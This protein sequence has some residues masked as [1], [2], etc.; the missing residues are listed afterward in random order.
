MTRIIHLTDSYSQKKVPFRPADD[1]R[2]TVYCCGPTVYAA[3]HIG[4]ARAG[5]VADQMVRLLR[6]VYGDGSVVYA[7]NLTDIDDKIIKASAEEGVEIDVITARATRLYLDDLEALGC[8]L[9]DMMP[10]ATEHIGAMQAMITSL[11]EQEFAYSAEGHVLFSTQAFGAYGALSRL[12]RDAMIAGARVEVAPYKR[13]PADFVLWKPAKEGEPGWDAPASWNIEGQGRPG[14]HI[15]CSAMIEENLGTPIDLH[16]GGLDLRFPHHEN[17]IAQSCC[18]KDLGGV[19]LARHWM[20][21][22]MLN[23]GADKM[24][25]SL[26]NIVTPGELLR[27]WH[28][29][30]LR[31]ALLSAHYRG[32]LEW[33][34]ELLQASKAQLDK[35]YRAAGDAEPGDLP[36]GVLDALADDLNTAGA[37]AA[38]HALREK[39]QAGDK[40]AKAQ[41]RAGGQLLGIMQQTEEAWFRGEASDDDARIDALLAERAEARKTRDF[42]RAD[43]IRDELSAEGIVIE[44]GPNGATWRRE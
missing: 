2:V 36:N 35:F 29:E 5:V 15:E 24:S 4:N 44:D 12:D 22:G 9:P 43:A 33:T 17:E 37:I 7:R 42:A 38:L 26:G 19:P 31:L 27:S 32:P 28:G 14:W 18:A 20:H 41:L 13:D 10:R 34:E 40:D 23:M 16:M 25:K 3:P 11:I 8:D 30:V 1:R 39:A 6:A 21:N